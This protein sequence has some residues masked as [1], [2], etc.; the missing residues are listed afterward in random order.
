MTNKEKFREQLENYAMANIL[1]G[2]GD[3][4][5]PKPCNNSI[6]ECKDCKFNKKSSCKTARLEWLNQEYQA[7]DWSKVEVDTPVYVR[8]DENNEWIPRY[9]A[10][11]KDGKIYTFNDGSTEFS[12]S[13][14]KKWNYAKLK[15]DVVK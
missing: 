4:N 8:N 10:D 14:L 15:E 9:F 1:W 5:T 7:V 11:Y 3:K 13:H 12:H 2:V 6:G